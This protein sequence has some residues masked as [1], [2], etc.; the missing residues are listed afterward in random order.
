MQVHV[1]WHPASDAACRPVAERIYVA[2]NRDPDQPLLPGVGIPVFFRCAGADPRVPTGVPRPIELSDTKLDLRIALVTAEMIEDRAWM[3]YLDQCQKE[4]AGKGRNAAMICFDLSMGGLRGTRLSVRIDPADQRFEERVMREVL[5]ACCRLLANRPRSGAAAALGAAPIKL[6]LSHTKRDE[7]GLPIA[8]ALKRHLDTLTVERFFDEVSITP[9][10]ELNTVL[11]AEIQDAALVCIRTD[12]Y[13][14]S[15]WC[16]KELALAK[17]HRRPMVVLDALSRREPRST[18]L[19]AHLP[20]ER[21]TPDDLNGPRLEGV[22]N[23]IALEIVRFLYANLQLTMLQQAKLV[24]DSAILLTRPPEARDLAAIIADAR[25]KKAGGATSEPPVLLHPDPM[26][27]AEEADDLA[28]FGATFVTPTSLWQKRLDHLHL[29]LSLSPGDA[30]EQKALGLSQ[31][32]E[33]AMRVIARQTL[34]AGATLHYGGV[35]NDK[36]LT[37]ALYDMIGAYNR[38]GLTLPPLVNHTPWPWDEEVDAN[39]RVLRQDMLTVE[40]CPPPADALALGDIP[41]PGHVGRLAATAQGRYALGR[42][43]GAMRQRNIDATGARVVLGGKPH[44]FVGFLPGIVEEVLLATRAGHPVYVLGGFGGGARLV[45]RALAGEQPDE[46]TRAYQEARSPDYAETL[47]YYDAVRTREPALGLP[48]IDYAAVTAELNR[49][50]LS[51]LSAANGLSEEENR[52]LFTTA[53]VDAAVHLIMRGL[54]QT[55]PPR[56]A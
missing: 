18:P 8:E 33:D 37:Q 13:V 29:G 28:P 47:R 44:G 7:T 23:V 21:V 10:D 15:P 19:L 9:G 16:R 1:L 54:T 52:I 55:P 46:L 31:H 25:K 32:I 36:S 49:Y 11:E 42:S 53:S 38:V 30:A 27:A 12:R 17:R 50:G 20:S 5:L 22:V 3:A 4:V 2:L 35:L 40:R 34:A 14:S 48:P 51:G 45:A 43:L 39:W 24:P 41:G 26:M 56:Q 6:F